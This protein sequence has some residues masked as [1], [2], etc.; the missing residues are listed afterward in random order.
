MWD[1]LRPGQTGRNKDGGAP[2]LSKK[3]LEQWQ[4]SRASSSS[5][6]PP[7]RPQRPTGYSYEIQGGAPRR[8]Q[9]D[10]S[11]E[12]YQTSAP[13]VQAP[14]PQ[15]QNN[16]IS[17]YGRP[18]SSIY[19]QPSPLAA[20]FAAQQLR[21]EVYADPAEISP[22]SSPDDFGPPEQP[23]DGDVSPIEEGN[24]TMENPSART[25]AVVRS[26]IPMMRRERRKNS[27]AAMHV[28][29]ESKS[30]ERLKQRNVADVRWD[31]YSGEPTSKDSARGL[32]SQ[33][34]STQQYAQG[35]ES[36]APAKDGGNIFGVRL[37]S[38]R[39]PQA[40]APIPTAAATPAPAAGAGKAPAEPAMTPSRPEWRG[41]SGRTP[42]VPPVK[43]TPDVPPLNVPP[44][45]AR[46]ANR[47]PRDDH[48][49]Q[50]VLSP[51]SS[52]GSETS[53]PPPAQRAT[54]TRTLSQKPNNGNIAQ[55]SASPVQRV[56]ADASDLP[57]QRYPSPALSD[58]NRPTGTS[59]PHQP[60][61]A[62]THPV[63]SNKPSTSTLFPPNEKAIRR[64]PPGA[65]G[66]TPQLST[67]S[68]TYSHQPDLHPSQ[69]PPGGFP[70]EWTQPPSRFSVTT[71]GTSAT[72]TPRL[73]AE[74]DAPALPTPPRQ[75]SQSPTKSLSPSGSSILDRKRPIV[76]GYEDK[77]RARTPSAE[78]IRINMDSPY[79]V[80][81]PVP[82]HPR[83]S[84]LHPIPR[85]NHSR[86]SVASTESSDKMLP[87][88]PPEE[89]ARDRVSQ[90]NAMLKSLGNRRININQAIRQMTEL[91]PTDNL[92]ASDAVIAKREAEKRK[93]EVLRDELADV[94]R[95]EYELGLKL[96][97]AYKRMDREAEYEPTGL[98]VR[99][100]TG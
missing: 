91:M 64:K 87:L 27:D 12:L 8:P 93:V 59:V 82:A 65:V 57:S 71:Y 17:S 81:S 75:Y 34:P 73:S 46:R 86:I 84:G 24:L 1:R 38:T 10:P 25:D 19:S 60:R 72:G 37:R 51:V 48:R 61:P 2:A 5:P 53:S 36:R 80:T 33:V 85:G 79:Y 66:H 94:Q 56:T 55:S 68:S 92:L 76:S 39:Q 99:R 49:G 98:W 90:L 74:E 96:H 44:K 6:T 88:A 45:S 97:R 41:A 58:D 18:A 63:P 16:R 3:K 50:G 22:P 42:L 67:S 23:N 40:P 28:L 54:T 69:R 62:A 77:P 4:N 100:V 11:S 14:P 21:N 31:K 52:L 9:R 7:A 95:E 13:A 89:S 78:P 70:E 32:P 26:Q 15:T 30:R 47:D 20:T 29:H 83:P 43:D 35:L